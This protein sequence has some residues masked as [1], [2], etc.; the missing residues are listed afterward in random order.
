MA[1]EKKNILDDF[2]VVQGEDK[3][4]SRVFKLAIIGT[5][6]IADAYANDINKMDDVE[7]IAL[8]EQRLVA[9]QNKDWATSDALRDKIAELG[10]EIKDGKGVYTLTKK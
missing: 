3:K 4:S 5:G 2:K 8:A 10:Y 7:V 6:W 1:E 9:R